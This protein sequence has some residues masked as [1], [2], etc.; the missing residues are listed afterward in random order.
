MLEDFSGGVSPGDTELELVGGAIDGEEVG[1]TGTVGAGAS[2]III[3][4]SS[5][6]IT[7]GI[8]TSQ[9]GSSDSPESVQESIP[10]N[11]CR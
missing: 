9:S 4:P 8:V 5:S 10:Q 11:G 1:S 2:G 6:N 7:L 3:A